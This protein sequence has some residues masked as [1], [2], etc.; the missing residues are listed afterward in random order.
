[1]II[2]SYLSSVIPYTL[3]S[4]SSI[5]RVQLPLQGN[6][7]PCIK[8]TPLCSNQISYFHS[9]TIYQ[10][11]VRLTKEQ[12]ASIVFTEVEKLQGIFK[13]K[14]EISTSRVFSGSNSN[15][16]LIKVSSREVSKLQS[17][18]ESLYS[19]YGKIPSWF[20]SHNLFYFLLTHSFFYPLLKNFPFIQ[21]L[22]LK[23]IQINHG[24]TVGSFSIVETK[25]LNNFIFFHI[26][27]NFTNNPVTTDP[28]RRD[29][30]L[31]ENIKSNTLALYSFTQ[32]R[33]L[34]YL[35]P[36]KDTIK[37]F[38]SL[39]ILIL[40]KKLNFMSPDYITVIFI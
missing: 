15:S 40:L 16:Y 13:S 39:Q 18:V 26:Y 6:I 12:K 27:M 17:I 14:F 8:R 36:N 20:I 35:D 28:K 38:I 2:C 37:I 22:N 33:N 24:N 1:M 7:L 25:K 34:F 5:K 4:C 19:F 29:F 9:S 31:K 11:A 32:L 3:K 10:Y 23:L 30:R 21:F